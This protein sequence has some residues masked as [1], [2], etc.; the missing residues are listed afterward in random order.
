MTRIK[1]RPAAILGAAIIVLATRAQAQVASVPVEQEP[2]H[3]T[4]FKNRYVQLF[5]VQLAPGHASQMHTHTHDDA[6][7][8]LSQAT[9]AS[10]SP[11]QA[12]GAPETVTPGMVSARNNAKTPTTH[13][14]HNVGKTLFDVMDVQVLERPEGPEAPALATPVAENPSLRAYRYDLE[15][16]GRSPEH[17]HTR[18]YVIVA[19]TPMS[20]EMRG[21]DG[22]T[23]RD[24]LKVG[25][26]HWVETKV[27]HVLI[28]A[29]KAKGTLV[30]VELK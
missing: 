29:G 20:L 23:R 3:K 17:T 2:D 27:T 18:P 5:R 12:M 11:G 4:V 25:D 8:R 22:A 19:A 24:Q 21:P 1:I 7:V 9:T 10:E 26:H 13:R 28:N 6:A 15:P 30:E 14:V 16:A